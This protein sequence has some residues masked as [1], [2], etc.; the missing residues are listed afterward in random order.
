L[1]DYIQ[2]NFETARRAH[3]AGVQFAM[4][5]DAVFTM[6]GQNT[7]ELAWFVKAGMTPEEALKTATVNAAALLG[8][9]D[10]LGRVKPGQYADLIAI[11]GDPLTD[12]QAAIHNVRGVMKGGKLI[13]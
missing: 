4:G 11:E 2:R 6:F 5:S 7:R 10:E 3:K 9:S 13:R 1:S 8:K 12:I